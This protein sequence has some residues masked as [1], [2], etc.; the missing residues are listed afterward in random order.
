MEEK[1]F[2]EKGLFRIGQKYSGKLRN[3]G[4]WVKLRSY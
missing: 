1:E 2:R 4:K 3:K